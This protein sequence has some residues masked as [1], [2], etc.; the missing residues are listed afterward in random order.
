MGHFV[1]KYVLNDEIIYIGKNDTDL[2]S[3]LR[4]H[5]KPGDNI[6]CVAWK[7]INAADIYYIKLY[8][9]TMSDVVESEL[10]RRYQPK[11]N[12]AKKN[13]DWAGLPFV[14]PEWIKYTRP[15]RK[16]LPQIKVDRPSYG[17]GF[18]F[19]WYI[20]NAIKEGYCEIEKVKSSMT[21]VSEKFV[22]IK[23]PPYCSIEFFVKYGGDSAWSAIVGEH[24]YGFHSLAMYLNDD[25]S[26]IEYLCGYMDDII[27]DILRLSNAINSQSA[28]Y[29]MIASMV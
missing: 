27:N 4:T 19:L 28:V 12:K 23:P 9:A 18:W 3:R 11:Y 2:D 15:I 22:K 8:N 25:A 24:T 5:G 20:L 6:S 26:E 16:T 7:D 17:E 1:Y 10:I 29:T 13:S 14:E 21:G